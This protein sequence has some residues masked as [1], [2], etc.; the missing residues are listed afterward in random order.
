MRLLQFSSHGELSL[1]KDLTDGVPPYAILSHTWGADDEEVKFNDLK[2]ESS[3]RKAGYEKIQFCGEQA[4]K[5]GL[6][7]FWVDTCCIDKANN[8]EL[9]EA[10]I[11]MFNWYRKA[12]KCYVYLSD[13]SVYS[14]DESQPK[15]TRDLAISKSRWFTRGWTLQ[16]LLAPKSVEFFSREGK[17]LGDRKTLEQEIQK[18]TE[19]PITALRGSPLSG[20]SVSE[21]IRWAEKRTT[22]RKEDKAYCLLGIFN[23]SMCPR[24]GE[25]E[26]AFTRLMAKIYPPL[27]SLSHAKGAIFNLND[28][29]HTTSL[30]YKG[31]ISIPLPRNMNFVGRDQIFQDIHTAV[32]SPRSQGS[33]CIKC[34]VHGMGGIGKTQVILEYAYR[35]RE[36]FSSIFWVRANSY[37]SAVE[38]YC[39]IA[40][41][42]GLTNRP[43]WKAWGSE[44]DMGRKTILTVKEWLTT[45]EN[46]NW[47]LLLDGWDDLNDVRMEYLIPHDGSGVVLITSRREDWARAGIA[48][49]LPLMEEAT[50]LSLLSKSSLTEFGKGS[51]EGKVI[52]IW[53]AKFFYS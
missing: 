41:Q 19:I 30:P 20:F 2:D 49:N 6:Q 37:D 22:N 31:S 28:M 4:Q 7:Y 1:T 9:T 43:Y 47:L 32:T 48:F 24:Y 17:L 27:R 8:T 11:S 35:Y 36:T 13:V 38:S 44:E 46:S 52:S 3:K 50:S 34:I 53:I 51:Q 33:D 25:E 15:W 45:R 23:V 5:D 42:I 40:Q 21:R 12:E 14:D 29:E 26:H 39:T 18:A 10:I 16:E